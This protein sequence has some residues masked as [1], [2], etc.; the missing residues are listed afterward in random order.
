MARFVEYPQKLIEPVIRDFIE[1]ME[2]RV[3][4][5]NIELYHQMNNCLALIQFRKGLNETKCLFKTRFNIS[6]ENDV[7]YLQRF[8]NDIYQQ[9]RLFHPSHQ[10]Y[11]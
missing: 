4:R 3:P 9:W 1:C 2:P 8:L 6:T 11:S 5:V 7:K 10:L